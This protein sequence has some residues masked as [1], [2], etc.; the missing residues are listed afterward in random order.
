MVAVADATDASGSIRVPASHCG[1]VGLKGSRGRLSVGPDHLC[2]D[3]LGIASEMCVARSVRDVAAVLDVVCGRR[4]G[5]P[6]SAP[7]PAK[8]FAGEV[9]SDPGRLRIGV[10]TRDPSGR[11]GGRGRPRCRRAP[12]RRHAGRSRS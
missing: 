2:D 5:D 3:L 10:L 7:P 6:Y 1:V 9:G 8:P 11:D 12:G 4:R